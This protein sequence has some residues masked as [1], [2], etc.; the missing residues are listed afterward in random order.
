MGQ[1]KTPRVR[2][3]MVVGQIVAIGVTLVA[4]TSWMGRAVSAAPAITL[5]AFTSEGVSVSDN[6]S[7]YANFDGGG[8]A[9][10]GSALAAGGFR[11]NSIVTTHG[12]A[13][14]WPHISEGARDNWTAPTASP[15]TIPIP[16]P[17][18]STVAFL[19][20]ST[21]GPSSGVAT[22]TFSDNS[23]RTFTLTLSD[24]TLNGGA[25]PPSAGNSIVATT[26]IQD[27]T[28]SFTRNV[29]SYLFYV[30]PVT[31]PTGEALVSVTLPATVTK[32]VLHIFSVAAIVPSPAFTNEG[33]SPTDHAATTA[34]FDGA[35]NS[36]SSAALTAAGFAPGAQV[37][38][39]GF[40]LTWPSIAAGAPDNWPQ[41]GQVVPIP[42]NSAG[43]LGILGASVGGPSSGSAT[44]IY[45]DGTAQAI[46]LTLSDWTLNNGANSPAGGNATAATLPY[47]DTAAGGEQAVKN[48][49]FLAAFQLQAG[50]TPLAVQLPATVNTGVMHVFAVGVI[51]PPTPAAPPT[52][53]PPVFGAGDWTA[54]LHDG[55]RSGFNSA[56]TTLTPATYPSL[57]QAWSVAAGGS[58]N[59]QPAVVNGVSYWGSWDGLLHATSAT[60]ASLWT[61]NLGQTNDASCDPPTAGVASSPSMGAVHDIASVFVAGG[62]S[63]FYAVNAANGVTLWSTSLGTSPSHFLW[64]S[65][66]IYNGSVYEGVSSFGDC[67]L[68]AGAVIQM[69][70]N[71][72]AV[73]HV[74]HTVP[75]GCTGVGVW[76]SVMVD[77]AT[78]DLYFATGNS[79]GC[80]SAEPL[81]ESVIAVKAS[82]LSLIGSW[83]IP[84]Q[85]TGGDIDF[86]STPTLFNATISGHSRSMLGIVN[87][88]G[89]YF[90]FDRTNISAGPL[91]S[92]QVGNGGD[93]P[94]CGS[95]NIAPSAFDGSTLYVPSGNTSI[96][97]ASCLGSV[98]ALN[99][100]T[101][102]PLWQDCLNSGTVLAPLTVTP[103][104]VL[105]TAGGKLMALNATTGAQLW[106]FA[107]T[108]S[109]SLFYG[110]A[111]VSNG[112]LYVGNMDG[113]FYAFSIGGSV[114]RRPTPARRGGKAPAPRA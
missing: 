3:W 102:A 44:I 33:I 25:A 5:P 58:I 17:S 94:Q 19:G 47:F 107:D 27:L 74:L 106:S 75:P 109:G 21:N 78:G 92:L 14:K 54:Y 41:A 105:V 6:I 31:V 97:G 108:T 39:G 72:G 87:K 93:C 86:G 35:G 36:Y 30:A 49:V 10:S 55:A 26:S 89:V 18:G 8:H 61:D 104:V 69:D 113:K 43:M 15:I 57:A 70:E 20:S 28:N 56:E 12:A 53:S 34:N 66:L 22:L 101:G 7:T 52:G 24:W 68:V 60:G 42:A 80:A 95:G 84:N 90:A 4:A 114:A 9:Y 38:V 45:T 96:N 73:E 62:N 76:G 16:A 64:S 88:D 65:P 85:P 81:A 13:F 51:P 29:T 48:Y 99:P 11:S 1:V 37:T 77:P 59:D 2:R 79:G 100:A 98:R 32:G 63:R 23:T 71:T 110:S 67:P 103:G 40:S 111:V 82:D 46:T 91:W 83:Q 50:K 112:R